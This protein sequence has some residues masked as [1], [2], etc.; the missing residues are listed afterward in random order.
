MRHA[1]KGIQYLSVSL[2][3]NV[4]AALRGRP[5]PKSDREANAWRA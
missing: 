1:A 5:F 3:T 2:E 4:R